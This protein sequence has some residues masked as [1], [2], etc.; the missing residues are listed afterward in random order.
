MTRFSRIIATLFCAIVPSVTG[1]M[2]QNAFDEDPVAA[3]GAV[4]AAGNA[5]FTVLTSRLVRMEWAED[6]RFEDR[7]SF[8]IVNRRLPVP[9]FSV[10]RNGQ[11]VTI[12]TDSLTIVYNGKGRFDES[13][14]SATFVMG[15]KKRTWRPGMDDS[16]NLLGTTRT[17]DMCDGERTVEPMEN[18]VVSRDGWAV[19]DEST[20]P[21]F[22]KVDADWKHWVVERDGTDR[23]DW[24]LFAY[25]HD[26]TAAVKDYTKVAGRIPLPP[27]YS[28]GYWWCRYWLY[29][30]FEFVDLGRQMRS[31]D[32]PVDVM[33]LDMDWHETWDRSDGVVEIDDF[34]QGKGWTGYTWRKDLFPN[35]ANHLKDLH[36]LGLRTTLNLHPASGI[37]PFED[38]YDAFVE[39]YLS[40]TDDYDGPKDFIKEDGSKASVPFRIDQMAWAES[41]TRKVLRPFEEIGVDFWWL[42]WQQWRQSRYLPSVSNTFWLNYVFFTDMQ[43]QGV[44]E[45]KYARRPMIYHRWGGLGSHR[46]QIGFSGDTFATWKVLGYLPWFTA[47]ASN[48]GYGYWGHDIGGHQQPSGVHETDPELYTRWLQGGVFTPIYKTHSTKDLTMEKRFWVFPDYFD[49]MRDAIRLRYSLSPYIYGAARQAYDTGISMCRPLYY[50]YPEND[51]A[52]EYKE[53]FMF[54][55]DILATVVCSPV[56]KETGLAPRKVWFPEGSDWYDAATGALYRGGTVAELLYRVEENPWFVR[57]GAVIPMASEKIKSLQE[58]SDVLNLFV[59]PGE[60][61]AEVRVYEDDGETQA[62]ADEFATTLVRKEAFGSSVKL[63]VAPREGS[64]RGISSVRALR[65]TLDGVFAPVSVRVNGVEVP[66]SRTAEHDCGEDVSLT[67]WTYKGADVAAVVYLAERDASEEVVVEVELPEG[68]RSLLDGAKGLIR[69][70]MTLTPDVKYHYAR[71]VGG[72]VPLPPDFVAV[73]QS[74]SYL[75]EDPVHAAEYISRWNPSGLENELRSRGSLPEDFVVRTLSAL[76]LQN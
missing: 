20:R 73:A 69:R 30:D 24:Y 55:D 35:P 45:G 52:Y 59:A 15:G 37:R 28:L 38:P 72:N 60:G 64:Y 14:L 23:L 71:Y 1:M 76:K 40:R 57:A 36:N 13:N 54:G 44:S 61:V 25:G 43:R 47:T 6:G 75:T 67:A 65:V 7:A 39:D 41:Y 42:D 51:E 2:A 16:A 48:V 31:R 74:C 22:E 46:Y 18:G 26:Y 66:Y 19:V 62:Y 56:D 5:R 63:T 33:V 27:K 10:K 32:I 29:S 50:Y 3:P 34:G 11:K 9:R 17:L 58:K 68:D 8:A 21:L 53:E 4:V 70:C 12:R 49:A